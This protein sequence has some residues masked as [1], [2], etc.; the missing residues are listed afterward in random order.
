MN[1]SNNCLI[2]EL[3]PANGSNSKPAK[4]TSMACDRKAMFLCSID[5]FHTTKLAKAPKLSC[6]H[7]K[8]NQTIDDRK[9]SNRVKRELGNK[10]DNE[11]IENG[12]GK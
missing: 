11:N 3:R 9:E 6:L 2:L 7:S 10:G 12:G 4:I 8:D 1:S 5:V